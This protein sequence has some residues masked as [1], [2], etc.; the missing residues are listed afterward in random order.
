MRRLRAKGNLDVGEGATPDGATPVWV[1][2]K[3]GQAAALELLIA[4]RALNVR[5]DLAAVMRV[6]IGTQGLDG[7]EGFVA[8]LLSPTVQ[9]R[10]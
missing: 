1:A 5:V 3:T 10:P 2:T 7:F 6:R 4:A 8:Y 9:R